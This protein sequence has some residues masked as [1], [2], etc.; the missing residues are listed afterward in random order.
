[1]VGLISALLLLAGAAPPFPATVNGRPITASELVKAARDHLQKTSYHKDPSPEQLEI[2]L[3]SA[4]EALVR[5]ELRAQEARRRGLAIAREPIQKLAAAEEASAGGKEKFDAV[6]SANG[7]DRAR[8]LEVIERPELSKRL[9]ESVTE[10][11]AEPTQDD[12]LAHYRKDPSRY[13]VEASAHVQELCVRVATTSAEDGWKKGEGEA[14]ELRTRL[15]Q[16][17][18]FAQAARDARCDKFAEKGGDLG[19]VH[20]GSLDSGMDEALWKLNDGELSQPIR[21]IRGWHIIRRV[22]THPS[23]AVP[24]PEVEQAIRAELRAARRDDA[25]K[26]LDDDLRAKAKVVLAEKK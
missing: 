5:D 8:Y 25:M 18:D 1:M 14:A 7:I 13:V 6:L 26:R 4:L 23:R 21:T 22:E 16:G 24:F 9:V 20:K 19:F 2:E 15:L 11:L 17:A 10:K 12:A 3:K